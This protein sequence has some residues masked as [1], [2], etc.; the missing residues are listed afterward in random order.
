[1]QAALAGL[2]VSATDLQKLLGTSGSPLSTAG[3]ALFLLGFL[4]F[5][6]CTF[7]QNWT[8][9]KAASLRASAESVENFHWGFPTKEPNAPR[10]PPN[11]DSTDHNWAF[12]KVEDGKGTVDVPAS[13][14][15]QYEDW[16]DKAKEKGEEWKAEERRDYYQRRYQWWIS[17]YDDWHEEV[18]Q[19]QLDREQAEALSNAAVMGVFGYFVRWF[20]IGCMVIG[21]GLLLLKG[22]RNEQ[23]VAVLVLGVG[24]LRLIS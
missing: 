16:R 8:R 13:E 11:P 23:L 2:P 17:N 10:W 6:T 4:V 22:E 21:M 24:L 9:T 3:K 1:M 7:L 14:I 15:K 20:G 19:A 12:W 5:G 18:T